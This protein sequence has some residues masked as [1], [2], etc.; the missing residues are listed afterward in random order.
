MKQTHDS[1]SK[2]EIDRLIELFSAKDLVSNKTRINL[3]VQKAVVKLMDDLAPETSRGQLV[4][5]LVL[6]E[7][8][9]QSKSPYGLFSAMTV[10]E[11][12]IDEVV[13]SWEKVIDETG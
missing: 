4:T 12:D 10:P 5:D 13:T 9:R 2:N 6:K 7:A 1:T 3:Y 8:K 11:K